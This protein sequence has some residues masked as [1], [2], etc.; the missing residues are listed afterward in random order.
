MM[1][2]WNCNMNGPLERQ[3]SPGLKDVLLTPSVEVYEDFEAKL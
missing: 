2:R 1:K 3:S